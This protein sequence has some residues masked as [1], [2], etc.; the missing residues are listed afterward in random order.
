MSVKNKAEI[1]VGDIVYIQG[2]WK[3]KVLGFLEDGHIDCVVYEGLP[4]KWGETVLTYDP[5]FV[6]IKRYAKGTND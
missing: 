2:R 3:A 5:M 6:E 4:Q 1:K